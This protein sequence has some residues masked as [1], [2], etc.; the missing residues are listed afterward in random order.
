[1][2]STPI[3]FHIKQGLEDAFMLEVNPS[4]TL[5]EVRKKL[6]AKGSKV[7]RYTKFIANGRIVR[8]DIPLGDQGIPDGGQG[9]AA[10]N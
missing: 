6:L 10:G 4:D 7:D 8:E 1:M 2:D 5:T 3:K 9:Y